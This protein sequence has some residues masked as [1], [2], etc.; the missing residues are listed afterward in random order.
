MDLEIQMA[1]LANI[2]KNAKVKTCQVNPIYTVSVEKVAFK[3]HI[4]LPCI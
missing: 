1:K 2:A 3:F 4:D